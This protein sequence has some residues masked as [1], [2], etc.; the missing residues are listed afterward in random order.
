[1]PNKWLQDKSFIIWRL[2]PTEED[3]ACWEDFIKNNPDRKEEIDDAIRTLE[4]ARINPDRYSS[5][6]KRN[7]FDSVQK[8]IEKKNRRKRFRL[9]YG[10]AAAVACIAFL[11]IYLSPGPVTND[12][13]ALQNKEQLLSAGEDISAAHKEIQLI[14]GDSETL[15][16]K[17]GAEI[18][19]DKQG[20]FILETENGKVKTREKHPE[21]AAVNTLVVPK[22][23]RANLILPD[24]SKVWIN[25]GSTF[26]FPAA[27]EPEKREVWID[28]EIYIEV[29]RNE[30]QPF[31]VHTSRMEIDVL[32]TSFNVNAYPEDA[33]H[34]VIL[35][36]GKVNV[37]VE[38]ENTI[39]LPNRMLSASKDQVSVKEVDVNNY[40]SWKEGY[41]QFTN[42]PLSDILNRLSRYYDIPIRCEG[43]ISGM[44]CKGKLVLFDDIED[45][46]ET[47][48]KTMP[49]GYSIEQ[50]YI[51]VTKRK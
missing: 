20:G 4:L 17:N 39:L 18:H 8:E 24:G 7:I 43:D 32:G 35:V 12:D 37:S 21:E 40:I 2:F 13:A 36:N 11:L 47:I 14:L 9:Y 51:A 45:V 6:E 26:K 25:S 16:L 29:E 28:G 48:Y 23:R 34:K 22:G 3:D 33:E 10:G 1:M 41:L 42:E 50:D 30:T 15:I 44:E 5:K 31:F 27:F 46:L 49:V 38:N 19:Y